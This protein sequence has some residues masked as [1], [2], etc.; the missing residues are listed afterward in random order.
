MSDQELGFFH[1]CLNHSWINNGLPSDLNEL[2][3][4]MRVK[5]SYITKVWPRVGRCFYESEGKLLNKRQESERAHAS[6]KSERNTRA[7]R[8]RYERSYERSTDE[9]QHAG[10]R[11][12]SDSVSDSVS[13]SSSGKENL[14]GEISR[15]PVPADSNPKS[16]V[17]LQPWQ[18]DTEFLK[19]QAS[20]LQSS[21]APGTQDWAD[22]YE[23]AWKRLD[24]TQKL[25]AVDRAKTFGAFISL[26]AKYLQRHEWTRKPRPGP[27]DQA[28]NKN[29]M[30]EAIAHAEKYGT[31]R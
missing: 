21:D 15:E 11:P 17:A 12:D 23:F 10:A 31:A 3:R 19:F 25:S 26:P 13:E 18:R 24:Y 29:A 1:R 20:Y 22:A 8:T 28:S 27:Q 4:A 6:E 30:A 2:A 14:K 7:V 16:T 5:R 9:L